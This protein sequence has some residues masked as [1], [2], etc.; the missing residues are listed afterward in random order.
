VLLLI[1]KV[2]EKFENSIIIQP[3]ETDLRYTR[4]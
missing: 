4:S 3:L 1:F 2:L